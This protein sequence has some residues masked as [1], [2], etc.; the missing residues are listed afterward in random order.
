MTMMRRQG[1]LAAALLGVVLV[2]PPPAAGHGTQYRVLGANE[3]IVEF[4]YTDG[5][6]MAFTA[7]R[8][9]GPGDDR[10]PIRSGR[11]DR[12]GRMAFVPDTDGQWRIEV[13]DDEGHAVRAAVNAAAG[14]VAAQGE[15]FPHWLGAISLALNA[16]LVPV[17]LQRKLD[18]SAAK[19]RAR[20]Q[21]PPGPP[22]PT[23]VD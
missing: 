2:T 7:F 17:V 14:R 23:S 13:R 3:T 22:A 5:Q 6:P 18:W 9:F 16:L 19:R 15:S 21:T 10:V 12:Q 20:P 11:T 8:L 1:G 4:S